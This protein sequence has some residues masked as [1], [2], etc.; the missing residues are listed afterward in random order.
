MARSM[1]SLPQH[2]P[3]YVGCN[4]GSF[5]SRITVTQTTT[6]LA[7]HKRHSECA[8]YWQR[9][10][11]SNAN[12]MAIELSKEARKAAR[13]IHRALTSREHGDRSETWGDTLLQFS[14]RNRPSIYNKAVSDVQTRMQSG[15]WNSM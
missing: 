6:R 9:A 12:H 14:S 15:S 7:K 1:V 4:P 8:P 2:S 11:A 3:S 10:H 5:F 13:F